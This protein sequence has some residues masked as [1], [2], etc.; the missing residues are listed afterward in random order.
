MPK[1]YEEHCT[2]N[3]ICMEYIPYK[4]IFHMDN[5][6]PRIVEALN[7]YIQLSFHALFHNMP[8]SLTW[9]WCLK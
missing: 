3:V 2:D 4:T 7:S 6:D 1:L 9:D 8:V 5:S